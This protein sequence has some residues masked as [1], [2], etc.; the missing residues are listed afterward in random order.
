MKKMTTKEQ[1][2][3][4]NPVFLKWVYHNNPWVEVHWQKFLAEHPEEKGGILAFKAQ[5]SDLKFLDEL[6]NPSEKSQLALNIQEQIAREITK[7]RKLTVVYSLMKYAAV[8]LLFFAIGG[9]QVYFFMNKQDKALQ[10]VEISEPV[11][12]SAKGPVLITSKGENVQLLHSNSTIDY[13]HKEVIILNEDSIAKS[14]SDNANALNQLVIPYGNQSKIVLSDNTTVW[15]NAGSR[16]LYPTTFN[17]KTREVILHGEGYFEVSSDKEHPFIV[18]TSILDVRVLGTKFNVSAYAEDNV[19]QTVLKEGSVAIRKKDAGLFDKDLIIKPNEMAS[20]NKTTS[21]T[22]IYKVDADYYRLWTKGLISFEDADFIRVIKKVE[23]FY[24]VSVRF[25]ESSK[26]T[27][28]I[29]GKLD[30][31]QS[32]KEVMEY[33]AKVSLSKIEQESEYKYIIK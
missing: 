30:L 32:Q 28:R 31:K 12:T 23:R 16:L 19:V 24:N 25:A 8:A 7:K 17:G 26:E 22:N 10:F 4:E 5:L 33:L 21:N 3:I 1:K 9:L 18:K 2:L 20:F 14:S 11:P 6:L 29:S 15:L 13:T 27:I